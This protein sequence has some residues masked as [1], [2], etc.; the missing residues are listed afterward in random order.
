MKIEILA[1]AD[2]VARQGAA[3]IAAES[4]AAVTARGRFILAVSGGHTPWLMLQALAR[5]DVPWDSVHVVQVDEQGN[6]T[7]ISQQIQQNLFEERFVPP[8][9][10]PHGC[11]TFFA[12]DL[13]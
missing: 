6:R 3:F 11:Q 5:E 10:Q 2:A 8:S 9:S 1:D 13:F 4:R 7:S 12:L